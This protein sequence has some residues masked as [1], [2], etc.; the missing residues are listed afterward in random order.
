M[1]GLL[2]AACS[3][4]APPD[5]VAPTTP[6]PPVATAA[7]P[8][9]PAAVTTPTA[10]GT[11]SSGAPT[12]SAAVAD[13]TLATTPATAVSPLDEYLGPGRRATAGDFDAEAYEREDRLFEEA[14]ARCMAAEGFTYVPYVR[15]T[16]FVV[17]GEGA[18]EL[19]TGRV[20]DRDGELSEDEY[21]A[22]YGYGISTADPEPTTG[23]TAPGDPEGDPN[24]AIVDAMSV[25]ERVAY[26]Q[27]LDGVEVSLSD[28]GRPNAEMPG[29][30]ASCW[31]R[32]SDEVW[33]DDE[34]VPDALTTAFASLL[35]Q[36][37]ALTDAVPAD[38]RMVDA[39]GRWSGCL[40]AAG[41][42]G[43]TDINGPQ[44]DV[45]SR[46]RDLLGDAM[47]TTRAA[48]E[49]LAALRQFEIGIATA[50]TACRDDY[51]TT[52]LAVEL[53]VQ[54]RFVADH[55]AELEQYRDA[56]IAAAAAGD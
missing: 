18:V 30:P 31:E 4:S 7:P 54:T 46:A 28:E 17:A 43:Y 39:L 9:A 42:P 2:L 24:T 21:A 45:V 26:F 16:S 50:D 3:A 1:G 33:G 55:R 44:S 37:A 14:K 13:T 56:A 12:T 23:V 48:P 52:F 11:A 25:P 51:A 20:D 5:A 38:P 27:A 36:V 53:D 8:A 10:G 49:D 15:A 22:R 40:A 6:S 29:D 35:E 41:F 47:D 34:P 19:V 32:A